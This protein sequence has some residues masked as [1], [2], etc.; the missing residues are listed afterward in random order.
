MAFWKLPT[1][2]LL[3][4]TFSTCSNGITF[5]ITNNCTSTIWPGTMA[6]S[7]TAQLSRTGFRLEAG[8]S[9]KLTTSGAKWSGRIWGRTGCKFD[10]NGEGKCETGD[11]GGKLECEGNGAAPPV[12]LF[13]ITL[14]GGTGQDFYDVSLVDGYNL[15][16]LVVP[17]DVYGTSAC[18]STGCISNL[19][20]G[21][22][23]EL[24]VQGSGGVIGCRSACEA[25]DTDQYCCRGQHA[26][27]ATCP[28][29]QYSTMFKKAC[30]RAY[31]YA[32]DD[33]TSTFTC[34]AYGYHI[35][36]CPSA[37][38]RKPRNK[39]NGKTQQVGSSNAFSP[40]SCPTSLYIAALAFWTS[41]AT[42]SF[43]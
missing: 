32:Y 14:G 31:S 30:P 10:G 1:L 35:I 3:L 33:A 26:G 23:K 34:K 29:S 19:N 11:C 17:A 9:V 39:R 22:P 43:T 38:S 37:S 12:S 5:T 6:G 13:E 28:P 27:P 40:Y 21:C 15:P 7:G 16:M 18:N 24:Q 2:V 8:R 41:M 42:W 20:T 36:F 25:F 4:F